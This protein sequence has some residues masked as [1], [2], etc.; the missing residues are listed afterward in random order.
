MPHD[1]GSVYKNTSNQAP[2]EE[3]IA[4]AAANER[5]TDRKHVVADAVI[6]TRAPAAPLLPVEA[7][8][9]ADATRI[10]EAQTDVAATVKTKEEEE[11]RTQVEALDPQA[12]QIPI[13]AVSKYNR[14]S[15]KVLS[16]V[17]GAAAATEG[18]MPPN[19]ADARTMV[20][21]PVAVD[22]TIGVKAQAVPKSKI[23]DDPKSAMIPRATAQVP[24][25]IV[26]D[27]AKMK[28]KA[29]TRTQ[30][31]CPD[32]QAEGNALDA[33]AEVNIAANNANNASAQENPAAT[34]TT[35]EEA[36]PRAHV[37]AVHAADDRPVA[38][39]NI[40]EDA[41]AAAKRI[42]DMATAVFT[43]ATARVPA[44]KA[45]EDAKMKAGASFNVKGPGLRVKQIDNAAEGEV[46]ANKTLVNVPAAATTAFR[47]GVPAARL[48]GAA[49]TAHGQAAI[50]AKTTTDAEVVLEAKEV[51][52][53]QSVVVGGGK[54]GAGGTSKPAEG[55]APQAKQPARTTLANCRTASK[56]VDNLVHVS[57]AANSGDA[58]EIVS[59]Q[60]HAETAIAADEQ[61]VLGEGMAAE[62]AVAKASRV[63]NAEAELKSKR[64][65]RD[66]LCESIVVSKKKTVVARTAA[67]TAVTTAT[68]AK[69]NYV[70]GASTAEGT[71]VDAQANQDGK[72]AGEAQEASDD[73]QKDDAQPAI[74]SKV[75]VISEGEVS[76]EAKGLKLQ[77]KA[78][79]NE[80]ADGKV[81]SNKEPSKARAIAA[82]EKA[83]AGKTTEVA[84][85]SGARAP[86]NAR[87]AGETRAMAEA[88]RIADAKAAVVARATARVAEA[89][90]AEDAKKA[91]AETRGKAQ[92]DA[93]AH[94]AERAARVKAV[95]EAKAANEARAAATARFGY[96]VAFT[97]FFLV[98][99]A[100][101]C[102]CFDG[103]HE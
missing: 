25:A 71:A 35:K 8:S 3:R 11:A 64:S 33:I 15:S 99:W 47:E 48:E 88:K 75:K 56:K 37:G 102:L 5:T 23:I 97:Y 45:R 82:T 21:T 70:G 67:T 54:M 63:A 55:S 16:Q 77:V 13:G 44:A 76:T 29:E 6:D 80:P 19:H 52:D 60:A 4:A 95:A 100:M 59:A 36:A 17:P 7:W 93:E 27:D 10:T 28:V 98:V 68:A 85:V 42:V 86:V 74:V 53:A 14:A 9:A 38:D 92:A 26:A 2:A 101:W 30:M 58:K 83:T 57:A 20:D 34:A 24:K 1:T 73:K 31:I 84:S 43:R 40:A 50:D 62:G 96:G 87:T 66:T 61:V 65:A 41:V 39:T 49:P 81:A 22:E 103:A 46:A 18:Y 79:E 72:R 69:A 89:K 91:A 78:I 51:A 32:L 94:R 12:K 90:A